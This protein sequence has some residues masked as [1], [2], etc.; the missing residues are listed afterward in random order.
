MVTI[1]YFCIIYVFWLQN[2]CG[3]VNAS[4]AP[5]AKLALHVSC[6]TIT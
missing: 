5:Q 4:F 2:L 6:H 1:V 3:V